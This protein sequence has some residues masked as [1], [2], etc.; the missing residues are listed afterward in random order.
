MKFDELII[1][2]TEIV[3]GET[4]WFWTKGDSGAW[5]GPVEDWETSHKEKYQK[6]LKNKNVVVTAGANQG[7]YARLYSKIFKN[8]YAFEP[9]ALN[10][11]CLCL[12]TPM[13]N[14]FKFNCGLGATP[15]F[16]TL[17]KP[18]M[19]NTGMHQ[20]VQHS[21]NVPVLA[22]DSFNFPELDLLQLDVEGFE[23]NV[24]LGAAKTIKRCKPVI[25]LERARNGNTIK[26]MNDLG[27]TLVEDSK[28]DSIFITN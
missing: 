3:D 6:Y 10:F 2:K 17:I 8:V 11:H 18:D 20:F 16:L 13:E 19:T 7:L 25:V 14:V 27:Y 22:L 1:L 28:M 12:N 4:N 5:D 24:I 26:L 21:G 15:E 23:Y 9:D